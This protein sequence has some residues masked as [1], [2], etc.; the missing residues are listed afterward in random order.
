MSRQSKVPLRA[1][2][3]VSV[4]AILLF[5]VAVMLD[6]GV[7]GAAGDV[8]RKPSSPVSGN[9]VLLAAVAFPAI[10]LGF[11]IVLRGAA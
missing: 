7:L 4:V 10:M 3:F 2:F 9:W 11:L 1:V 6:P 5:V 8:L